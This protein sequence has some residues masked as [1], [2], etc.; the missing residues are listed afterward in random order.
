MY[1]IQCFAGEVLKGSI[2]SA[3]L[4]GFM[5]RST[6][7]PVDVFVTLKPDIVIFDPVKSFVTITELTIP[8]EQNQ[9][10]P[11]KRKVNK[12]SELATTIESNGHTLNVYAIGVGARG[13]KDNIKCSESIFHIPMKIYS[14]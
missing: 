4:P 8:F 1:K 6:T 13:Y 3:D 9:L 10:E 14:L 2:L 5:K 12:Y 7:I 11:H